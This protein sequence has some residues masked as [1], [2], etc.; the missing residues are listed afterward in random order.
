VCEKK[1]KKKNCCSYKMLSPFLLWAG[2]LQARQGDS[3]FAAQALRSAV[4]HFLSGRLTF[5]HTETK[6]DC[7]PLEAS[8]KLQPARLAPDQS[9]EITRRFLIR[10][11][12]DPSSKSVS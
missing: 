7:R 12:I 3:P 1:R 11:L 6:G 8:R 5:V 2:V 4:N 9:A 10:S